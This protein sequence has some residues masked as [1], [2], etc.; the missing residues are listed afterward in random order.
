MKIFVFT[1]E[2]VGL[3]DV[4]AF[5]SFMFLL[6]EIEKD[7]DICF[8]NQGPASEELVTVC[9]RY[10]NGKFKRRVV[11][12]LVGESAKEKNITEFFKFNADI[13]ACVE[14]PNDRRC[15]LDEHIIREIMNEDTFI[16]YVSDKT[17][18]TLASATRYAIKKK[19]PI[20]FLGKVETYELLESAP[21][22]QDRFLDQSLIKKKQD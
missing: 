22:F 18:G 12:V 16:V 7:I 8:F 19:L 17:V 21:V 6:Q 5:D 10:Q 9:K 20:I 3:C 11:N 2:R 13:T 4:R 14:P 15:W 1:E